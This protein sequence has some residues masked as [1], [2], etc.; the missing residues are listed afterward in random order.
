MVD[1]Q[2]ARWKTDQRPIPL[3][4]PC[5]LNGRLE[6]ANN[7]F[8]H[9]LKS[10]RRQ[11]ADLGGDEADVRREQLA[12][13]GVTGESERHCCEVVT[14]QQHGAR[15]GV[16]VTRD[17][18][19]HQSPRPAPARTTAGRSLV[20]DRSEN[21]NGTITTAPAEDGTMQHPPQVGSSLRLGPPH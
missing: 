21:G 2:F 14:L 17:L 16:R 13:T 6:Q 15:I 12:G 7:G 9:T 5:S 8:Q 19:Q 18:A 20:C 4:S 11:G 1:R 10:G 3:A